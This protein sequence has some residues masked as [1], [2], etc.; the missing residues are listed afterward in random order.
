[1][2]YE[3]VYVDPEVIVEHK[4]VTVYHAY[5]ECGAVE[6][7]LQCW[8]TLDKEQECFGDPGVF[9]YRALPVPG[10]CQE[11]DPV[12]ILKKAIDIGIFEPGMSGNDVEERLQVVAKK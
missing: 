10:A 1:M 12:T 9:D 3:R 11:A 2:P 7:R 4:G 6:D 5:D 8:F